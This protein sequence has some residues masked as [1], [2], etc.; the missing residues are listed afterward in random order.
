MES[1][2]IDAEKKEEENNCSMSSTFIL[3]LVTSGS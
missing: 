2:S 3:T 1:I